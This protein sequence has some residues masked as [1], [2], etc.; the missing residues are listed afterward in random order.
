MNK[1]VIIWACLIQK[2]SNKFIEYF[3]KLS[4]GKKTLWRIMCKYDNDKANMEHQGIRCH[5]K[6]RYHLARVSVQWPS[7]VD[8]IINFVAIKMRG[9]Y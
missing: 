1:D 7:L 4:G 6:G 8:I 3:N 2:I 9:D 5:P